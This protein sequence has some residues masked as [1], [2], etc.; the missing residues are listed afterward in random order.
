MDSFDVQLVPPVDSDVLVLDRDFT[1][2]FGDQFSVNAPSFSEGNP[3][4]EANV[5]GVDAYNHDGLDANTV[6]L[7]Y[8]RDQPAGEIARFNLIAGN[9]GNHIVSLNNLITL[10]CV[11]RSICPTSAMEYLLSFI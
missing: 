11:L 3:F 2:V 7:K 9:E 5:N 4:F 10:S 8:A 6:I 1:G